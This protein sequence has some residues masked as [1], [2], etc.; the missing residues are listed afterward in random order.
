MLQSQASDNR[1]SST[2]VSRSPSNETYTDPFSTNPSFDPALV[3]Y[4]GNFILNSPLNAEIFFPKSDLH[5]IPGLC[6]WL[7]E[8]DRVVEVSEMS[9]DQSYITITNS[10]GSRRLVISDNLF[11]YAARSD[12]LTICVPLQGSKGKP[13]EGAVMTRESVE[14][15]FQLKIGS[16]EEFYEIF[17]AVVGGGGPAGLT[18]AYKSQG[19]VILVDP[20]QGGNVR[21]T[22][23]ITLADGVNYWKSLGLE[24]PADD[25]SAVRRVD[26]GSV[27]FR[28]GSFSLRF[29]DSKDVLY[30]LHPD[31]WLDQLREKIPAK[32]KV[33]AKVTDLLYC[34]DRVVG[35]RTNSTSEPK[36]YIFGRETVDASRGRLTHLVRGAV[37]KKR[38]LTPYSTYGY[39][40]P[41]HPDEAHLFKDAVR[42]YVPGLQTEVFV[43]LTPRPEGMALALLF[44]VP[45]DKLKSMKSTRDPAKDRYFQ[46]AVRNVLDPSKRKFVQSLLD[47]K[48]PVEFIRPWTSEHSLTAYPLDSGVILLADATT[49]NYLG[50]GMPIVSQK[51]KKAAG[52]GDVSDA[53]ASKY[54]DHLTIVVSSDELQR[55][56]FG[57]RSVMRYIP[58]PVL[59]GGLKL[60]FSPLILGKEGKEALATGLSQ[61]I[62]RG[63]PLTVITESLVKASDEM[64][65]IKRIPLSPLLRRAHQWLDNHIANRRKEIEDFFSAHSA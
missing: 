29:P 38:D 65:W 46:Y 16:E 44:L 12:Q 1:G 47:N 30:L 31:V 42:T 24:L 10:S 28:V 21:P 7:E 35:V 19:N 27:V 17:D 2:P 56:L 36:R 49:N 9:S 22:D 61:V 58:T 60:V 39:T 57:E 18:Y 48:R 59:A 25:S 13:I 34:G 11:D 43:F 50:R 8:A 53:P 37:P 3:S 51:A 54:P 32:S 15:D 55:L 41:I 20:A 62:F 23:T 6:R 4:Y 52:G 5:I 40:V 14:K 26:A 33:K 45:T 64:C 63:E